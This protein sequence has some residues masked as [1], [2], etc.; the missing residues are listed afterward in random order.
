MTAEQ[1]DAAAGRL[2]RQATEKH[3]EITA[4]QEKIKN[5]FLSDL[6]IGLV[7]GVYSEFDVEK[8]YIEGRMDEGTRTRLTKLAISEAEKR[9]TRD[10]STAMVMGALNNG[11]ALNP[12]NPDVQKAVNTYA[13]DLDPS[14]PSYLTELSVV[15][16][17]T[18]FM[19]QKLEDAIAGKL[20]NGNEEQAAQALQTYEAL[21]DQDQGK[22]LVGFMPDQT[23]DLLD[24]AAYFSRAGAPSTKAAVA[25]A[26]EVLNVKPEIR[27]QRKIEYTT[28]RK[29]TDA[30]KELKKM[31]EKDSEI[32]NVE[33]NF[34]LGAVA[35]VPVVSDMTA[36]YSRGVELYYGK[37][38]DIELA[39]HM[40][41]QNLQRTWGITEVAGKKRAMKF[42]P[43]RT[44]NLTTEDVNA[45]LLGYAE[46]YQVN[47]DNIRIV[48]D[49]YTARDLDSWR[50]MIV[51]PETGFPMQPS[52]V[53]GQREA[54]RFTPHDWV[55]IGKETLW[56]REAVD[57]KSEHELEM[58]KEQ[59]RQR[60]KEQA[61][62]RGYR[63]AETVDIYKGVGW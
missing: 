21:L 45:A 1:R 3:A 2:R 42:P 33:T 57:V 37:T 17:K 25:Q 8:A 38:G 10:T 11:K 36:E 44:A 20:I 29:E 41:Y 63:G 39:K 32:F 13:D 51:D 26:K 4:Q 30:A 53:I 22:K 48:S 12:Y 58:R 50:V 52:D 16:I 59:F 54:D 18:G 47:P 35:D 19:P 61:A 28:L 55:A 9:V 31:M 7:K 56:Q 49:S 27:E 24:T 60:V 62:K 40:A 46:F 6:E 5:K 14:S 43:E 34:G 23:K 15:A